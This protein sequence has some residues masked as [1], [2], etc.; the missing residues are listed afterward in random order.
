MDKFNV[1]SGIKI[2]TV[3]DYKRERKFASKTASRNFYTI[4]I[5]LEGCSK[6]EFNNK[7]L[8]INENEILL[9][10][11]NIS[12]K[13][14]TDL[15][16]RIIA[17]DIDAKSDYK[18]LTLFKC[19]RPEIRAN[20]IEISKIWNTKTEQD[21][22][23]MYK[24]LYEILQ[25]ISEEKNEDSFDKIDKAYKYICKNFKDYALSVENIADSL[26]ISTAYL[27]REFNKRYGKTPKRL[28]IDLRLE[29]AKIL[30]ENHFANVVE[31][32]TQSGF[33]DS[34]Y[35]SAVFKRRYG[36]SPSDVLKQNK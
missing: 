17:I 5:R 24:L 25:L 26:N 7:K 1:L 30:L 36:V 8:T 32:S 20:F 4:S 27:R 31:A 18:E 3:I 29:S 2:R 11:P 10:P 16:D 34:N 22:Y 23:R 14:S 33:L 12:Y 15:G 6:F 21:Y 35:F 28:I 19:N 13:Q 9:V